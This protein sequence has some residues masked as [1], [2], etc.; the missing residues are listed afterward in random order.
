[1][2]NKSVLPFKKKRLPYI[3]CIIDRGD[4]LAFSQ[5]TTVLV[6]VILPH[7]PVSMASLSLSAVKQ[8]LTLARKSMKQEEEAELIQRIEESARK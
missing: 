8:I 7:H 2:I 4:H 1:M 5:A 6:L 3:R